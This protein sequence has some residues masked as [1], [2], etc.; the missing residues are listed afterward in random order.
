MVVVEVLE[1][2]LP[3]QVVGSLEVEDEVVAEGSMKVHPLKSWVSDSRMIR[4]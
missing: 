3:G 2:V 4:L 1:L